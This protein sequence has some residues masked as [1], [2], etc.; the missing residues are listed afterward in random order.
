VLGNDGEYQCKMKK[1]NVESGGKEFYIQ[2]KGRLTGFVSSCA[3]T[4]L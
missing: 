1:Y 4:A 2:Q 3:E